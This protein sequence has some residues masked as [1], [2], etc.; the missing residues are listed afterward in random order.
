MSVFLAD[1]PTGGQSTPPRVEDVVS[2]LVQL[3]SI[4]PAALPLGRS[5]GTKEREFSRQLVVITI[6]PTPK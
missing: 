2:I 6:S 4:C 5:A 1:A 3:S